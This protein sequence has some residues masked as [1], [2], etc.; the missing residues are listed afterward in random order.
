MTAKISIESS[1]IVTYTTVV[2][3]IL[4]EI[5]RLPDYLALHCSIDST[6]NEREDKSSSS[7]N[8]DE[9]INTCRCLNWIS[10]RPAL[11][12]IMNNERERLIL[13]KKK[14]KTRI[15]TRGRQPTQSDKVVSNK[16]VQLKMANDTYKQM[17][18]GRNQ[19][20]PVLILTKE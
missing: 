2:N 11:C 16:L 5:F 8:N 18:T 4:T 17:I 19:T 3:H 10:M 14:K 1:D 9:T 7:C 20:M 12:K 6:S 15:K 13:G